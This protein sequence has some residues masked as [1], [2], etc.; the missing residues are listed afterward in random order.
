M[1][2]Y[3][4]FHRTFS[5]VRGKCCYEVSIHQEAIFNDDL[6]STA[7]CHLFQRHDSETT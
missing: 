1:E 5:S 6:G 3:D 2:E 7:G 4:K